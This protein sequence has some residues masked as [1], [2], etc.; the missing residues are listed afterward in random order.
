MISTTSLA[1]SILTT[2]E[3]SSARPLL[4]NMSSQKIEHHHSPPSVTL[5]KSNQRY[6][7]SSIDKIDASLSRHQTLTSP[8]DRD[9]SSSCSS[10]SSTS[11][12]SS[13]FEKDDDL[14]LA[15]NS[16]QHTSMPSSEI[17]LVL[18]QSSSSNHKHFHS[19][20]C[21]SNH[22]NL[23]SDNN[24]NTNSKSNSNNNEYNY[25][26]TM[27]ATSKS[28]TSSTVLMQTNFL[29]S[30]NNKNESTLLKNINNNN[31]NTFTNNFND[32]NKLYLPQREKFN[33]KHLS[34]HPPTPTSS[35][36]SPLLTSKKNVEKKNL[37]KQITND[38]IIIKP[39]DEN[40]SKNLKLISAQT[41]SNSIRSEHFSSS[42]SSPTNSSEPIFTLDSKLSRDRSASNSL[43]EE[44][45]L[46]GDDLNDTSDVD[47][48]LVGL[49]A[50]VEDNNNN[51]NSR[52]EHL[53][54]PDSLE[55]SC[56]SCLSET[57]P[58]EI[59]INNYSSGSILEPTS[60]I[61]YLNSSNEANYFNGINKPVAAKTVNNSD[62]SLIL[63]KIKKINQ[64]Q[65]KI[66]DINNKIKHID[67]NNAQPA[68]AI[69]NTNPNYYS[70]HQ[71]VSFKELMFEDQEKSA[72]VEVKNSTNEN[73]NNGIH[74]YINPKYCDDDDEEED[75]FNQ[76]Y[77]QLISKRTS[78]DDHSDETNHYNCDDSPDNSER[79]RSLNNKTRLG[80]RKNELNDDDDDD[81][82]DDAISCESDENYE[83]IDR[84][85]SNNDDGEYFDDSE[86]L[87]SNKNDGN[88]LYSSRNVRF[89]NKHNLIENEMEDEN[90]NCRYLD[91]EDEDLL[92]DEDEDEDDLL[93]NSSRFLNGSNGS[94]KQAQPIQ[95]KYASTGFL[96]H[97]FG[98]YLAPIDEVSEEQV[99]GCANGAAASS[100]V[101]TTDIVNKEEA[102]L[103][104][105]TSKLNNEN[106][107]SDTSGFA[108]NN[109]SIKGSTSCFNL[110][111]SIKS[112]KFPFWIN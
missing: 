85:K 18:D 23:L 1:K 49:G 37:D 38:I 2:S 51:N 4:I 96:F 103:L 71:D 99:S 106:T 93:F 78:L 12:S 61:N 67:M 17:D 58:D 88:T 15:C 86:Y 66:N 39:C 41:N 35:S 63:E 77:N 100:T 92:E 28:S 68:S 102:T 105:D 20:C 16:K 5:I 33:I 52:N 59:D 44:K 82:N 14:G 80:I 64:L 40:V 7:F 72:Q 79:H 45:F 36:S 62:T 31:N 60:F 57:T 56:S 91:E 65:E 10:A 25:N 74:Y 109:I 104:S 50:R 110:S 76:Q 11:S 84:P 53:F 97:R 108:S 73:N 46:V 43:V 111:L 107:Q 90:V 21:S 87:D 6:E 29:S 30:I 54:T 47:E 75:S 69:A 101:T 34:H 112:S 32:N 3:S 70:L 9:L 55:S 95:K 24:L 8:N 19:D 83:Q 48:D 89:V 98:G 94:Y 13:A 81:F 42:S 27:T 26:S 22:L